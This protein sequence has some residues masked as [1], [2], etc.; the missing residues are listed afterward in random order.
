MHLRPAGQP[1]PHVEPPAL[2]LVVALDLIAKGR[3]RL[4]DHGHVAPDDVPEL[5]ELVDRGP[6]DESAHPRDAAVTAIDREACALALGADHHRA[7]LQHLEVPSI[8]PHARLAVDDRPAVLELDRERRGSEERARDRETETRERDGPPPC[9]PRRGGVP[10]G[11]HAA[12]DVVPEG[13]AV[14]Q[15]T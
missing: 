7:Q 12:A 1:R 8:L 14:A 3:A 4:A 13:C 6:A 11:R 9:S 15:V 2:S 5:R 10:G